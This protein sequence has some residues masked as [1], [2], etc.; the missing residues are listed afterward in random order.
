V[1]TI[2][3]NSASG[4]ASLC[5]LACCLL[6]SGVAGAGDVPEYSV[7]V[8]S[9]L[10]ELRVE[11]HFT[12]PV[13]TIAAR[14]RDAHRHISNVRDCATG[15]RIRTRGRRML[16]PQNGLRCITYRVDLR[17]AAAADR[18][19]NTLSPANVVVSP[20][21][22]MWRPAIGQGS[23]IHVQFILEGET[24]VSVPWQPVPG[25]DNAYRL[26]AS[27][28]NAQGVAV[29]GRFT[30][31]ESDIPG[32]RLRIALLQP[33]S[34]IDDAAIAAIASWVSDAA[35][36]VT[37]AYG[38][39]P[40]PSLQVVV[41]P[42]GGHSWSDSPVPF[43]RVIRDGGESVELFVDERRAIDEYYDD[44]TATHEF[45]H[46]MLPYIRSSNRWISEGFAQYYQNVLLA[47]SGAYSELQA[48]QKLYEGFER[49]RKSRPDLSPNRAAARGT[50]DATMKVYWTG[51]AIALIADVELRRRSNGNESLDDVLS[52]LQ[53]CCLP[54][55]R[56]WSGQELFAKLDTLIEVPLFM[57][58]YRRHANKTG[59]PD[60][61]GLIGRLGLAVDDDIVALQRNAEL[62]RIRH[63]ITGQKPNSWVLLKPLLD[64]G[65][66]RGQARHNHVPTQSRDRCSTDQ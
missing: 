8:D 37:L 9:A 22:W 40:N 33:R 39:F 2:I 62:A 42:V 7:R 12:V 3:I 60:L 19:N 11:A 58:L 23:H 28:E 52:R 48:W 51:A 10:H 53:E 5:G 47:R 31:V 24:L 6:A 20:S 36:N 46:L 56:T 49:G 15:K 18:R 59:F 35:S 1:R 29:F 27:P 57:P 34:E 17:Q 32:A 38:R 16:L 14:S 55:A 45:S 66:P 63:A 4:G 25:V 26:T 41:L 30:Y 61:R 43:G 54:S 50:R 44:W 64:T 65:Q 13:R 21:V